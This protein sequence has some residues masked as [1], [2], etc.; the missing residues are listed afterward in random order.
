MRNKILLTQLTF[1]N[2]FS[3][4]EKQI[5]T[6]GKMNGKTQAE[7]EQALVNYRTGYKPQQL[8]LEHS[9]PFGVDVAVGAAQGLGKTV[10]LLGDSGG[11]VAKGAT[12]MILPP[13]TPTNAID[14]GIDST[15]ESLQNSVGLTDENLRAKNT[16]QKVGQGLEFGAELAAPFAAG[17][18]GEVFMGGAKLS[19]EGASVVKNIA[20]GTG[21]Y[22]LGRIPKILSVI[23]GES[24]D[25]VLN[26]LK[27]PTQADLGIE[28]GDAAISEAVARGAKKSIE[29]K[30][31]F[32]QAH[33]VAKQQI[34][35]KYQKV[36]VPKKDVRNIFN[37]ILEEQ[38]V[39]I[40]KDGALDFTTSKINA[41]PG[42]VAKIKNAYEALNNWET[43][44]I[45]SLDEYKQLI[46]KYTR[47]ADD[48]GVPSKSPTLGRF[49]NELNQIAV[50]KLPKSISDEYIQMNKN[51]SDN[52]DLYDDMVDAFN[53]GTPF[54][55]LAN[56]LGK[57]ND[58]IRQILE[59]YQKQGGEDILPIVAGR[60]LA[61]DK[62]AN[63]FLNPRSLIDILISPKA[64]G[65]FVTFVGEKAKGTRLEPLLK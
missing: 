22:A 60:E 2:M 20:S 32:I 31:A 6:F 3:D 15:K 45:D 50:K 49:Y 30:N 12:K 10:K 14:K 35:G 48:A 62:Q 34:L 57:N 5:I 4:K 40:G 55:K 44:T 39:A 46:G 65:K 47:F 25:V 33:K 26:A 59:F 9:R 41:N 53:S 37:K 29:I 58:A 23:T 43:F 8:P 13:G 42:E 51:F 17:K 7:V 28:K 27:N 16:A 24:N 38:R 64:Q 52:I 56:A 19:K 63:F 18:I 36:L 54:T 61:M 1:T 11:M 21:E